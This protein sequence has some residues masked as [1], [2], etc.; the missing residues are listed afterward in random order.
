[1]AE[2]KPLRLTCPV[3]ET[4][5]KISANIER[6]SCLNCG[7]ELVV[8][9]N[10]DEAQLV[11]S[12]ASAA[13]MSNSQQRLIEINTALKRADDN[14]GVGC[15]VATMGITL[16]SCL[17]LS[18]SV[19]FQSQILFWVTIVLALAILAFV[20]FLF[21]TASSRNTDPLLRERDRLQ[22]TVEQENGAEDQEDTGGSQA[23]PSGA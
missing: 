15:A 11:P 9:H 21:I 4:R 13:Q 20:L 5:L 17:L 22:E 7:T 19:V 16:V 23:Q 14:Y 3:C 6:F 1:M 8:E 12:A 18:L 10:G 2:N